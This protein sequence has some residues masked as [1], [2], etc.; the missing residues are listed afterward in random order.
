M[1]NILL[2]QIVITS[3]KR[4][5]KRLFKRLQGKLQASFS[6]TLKRESLI[7]CLPDS[8]QKEISAISRILNLISITKG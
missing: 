1:L 5:E 3:G 8:L 2:A 6:Q 7:V 4:L